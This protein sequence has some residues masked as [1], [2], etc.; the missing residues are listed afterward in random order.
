M[1][2]DSL[3]PES[4]RVS[5]GTRGLCSRINGMHPKPLYATSSRTV[6]PAMKQTKRHAPAPGKMPDAVSTWEFPMAPALLLVTV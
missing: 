4:G 6:L 2:K 1:P 3:S 5:S